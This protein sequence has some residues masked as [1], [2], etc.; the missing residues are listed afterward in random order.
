VTLPDGRKLLLVPNRPP[1]L[2]WLGLLG[3]LAVALAVG[4]YPLARQITGRLERL[5]ARVDQLGAGDLAAR[6][7]VEGKDEVADL[8]RSFNRAAERIERL[9]GSQ[10]AMLA[11][12]SHE[13]RSPLARIRMA[14]ELVD[15]G[16]RPELRGQ[17]EHDIAELD[18]L[19]DELLLSSRMAASR[20]LSRREIMDLLALVAEE[21]ARFDAEATGDAVTV[22]GDPRLL[23]R[24]VRNL[25]DNAHRHGR[26]AAVRANVAAT[27]DGARIRVEDDG[28]GVPEAER[29][30]IFEPF[31][32]PAG[33]REGT[34]RGVGLG[35]ALVREIARRH[36]G[37]ARYEPLARGSRFE[38]TV[39]SAPAEPA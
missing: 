6:V 10:R 17:I 20:D 35:L 3:L 37:D 19:I 15:S 5:Q 27:A 30:R 25:L 32:R 9:V 29:E 39:G 38:V 2:R 18:E 23:R 8:A 28:P 22:T 21:A 26:G 14:L 13:L 33:M 36:G 34:D 4:A 12:A 11:A 24:M 7:R 1:R 16:A 31:Y